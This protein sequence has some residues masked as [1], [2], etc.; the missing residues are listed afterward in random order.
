MWRKSLF[1]LCLAAIAAYIL[2]RL[3][4]WGFN[5]S[6]FVSSLSNVQPGWMAASVLVTMFTYVA[7]AIR[8]RVLLNPLKRI[9]MGALIS[10]NVLG[11]SAI[12]LIGRPGELVR[13][14]W[15]TRR[16]GIPLTASVATIVVERVLDTLMLITMFGLALL[17]VHVAS[18]AEQTVKLLKE[19]AWV[20]LGSSAAAMIFL[21]FFRSNIDWIVRFV[22]ITKLQSL[23]RNFSAGLSFL[24]RTSTFGLALLY[25]VGVWITILLQFW[26][27]LLGM[28][29]H[30]SASAA[31]LV[32]IG[33]AIGS[34]AQVPGI[35]GGFQLGYAFCMTTFFGVP[36]EQAAATSLIVWV[37]S[38][39]PTV[40]LGGAYMISQGLSLKDLRTATAD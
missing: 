15:L 17:T 20:M 30:F 24:D 12:Y 2:Y 10:T 25:S 35:G 34:I 19:T 26:F 33:A 16:E 23:L 40:L 39:V 5:W 38:Y 28:N 14:I 31:T 36:A 21:F 32:M 8:W 6:L 37:T 9:P 4:S 18:A 3:G 22:P 7:R 1:F 13:P 11:F 27:M 29:F